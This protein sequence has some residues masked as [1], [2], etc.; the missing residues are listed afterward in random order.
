M[1]ISRKSIHEKQ[2]FLKNHHYRGAIYIIAEFD[3]DDLNSK[4]WKI[5]T[6]NINMTYVKA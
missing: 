3:S 4:L 6:K 1:E 5:V 2:A